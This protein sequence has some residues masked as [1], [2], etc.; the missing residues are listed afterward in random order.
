MTTKRITGPINQGT[1]TTANDLD[2]LRSRT[3]VKYLVTEEDH[4]VAAG[5][6]TI[7]AAITAA[8]AH[9]VLDANVTLYGDIP[10]QDVTAKRMGAWSV[11]VIINWSYPSVPAPDPGTSTG[12][13]TMRANTATVRIYRAPY[14]LVADGDAMPASAD[15]CTGT[16]S[17]LNDCWNSTLSLC[18]DS[19]MSS[20]SSLPSGDWID[21]WNRTTAAGGNAPAWADRANARYRLWPVPEIYLGLPAR[22]SAASF[23]GL[24]AGFFS[25]VG[26]FNSNAFPWGGMSFGIETL[27]IDGATVDWVNEDGTF[28]Y[29][30]QY[31]LSW[32]PQ[33][34]WTQQLVQDSTNASLCDTLDVAM[35]KPTTSFAA[36][37]PLS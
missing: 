34:W 13:L 6:L 35:S 10:M 36:L 37:M 1:V 15:N 31:N 21:G 22:L 28:V 17:S 25:K 24:Q 14:V 7:A 4:T 18:Q 11:E 3:Q 5:K 23:A 16:C 9:A 26:Y 8:A 30:V 29:Y 20:A 33:G 32:R 19:S 12:L 27:R 2:P